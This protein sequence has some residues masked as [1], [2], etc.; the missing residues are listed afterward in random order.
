MRRLNSPGDG[1]PQIEDVTIMYFESDKL[2]NVA[3][4][5]ELIEIPANCGRW[6]KEAMILGFFEFFD[7]LVAGDGGEDPVRLKRI[8]DAKAE[9]ERFAGLMGK[10]KTKLASVPAD[11]QSTT[12]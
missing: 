12:Q 7:K 5:R 8:A 4:R 1:K 11:D 2:E 3:V 10:V 6:A 9:L